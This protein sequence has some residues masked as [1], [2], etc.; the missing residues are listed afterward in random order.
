MNDSGEEKL[1]ALLREAFPRVSEEPR[2]LWPRMLHRLEA[3]PWRVPWYD[4]AA[5]ALVLGGA[6]LLR[7]EL[8]VV[9]Y[10]L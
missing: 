3:E 7:E 4:W 5:A 9:L 10:H 6:L 1:R 8:L 2:D